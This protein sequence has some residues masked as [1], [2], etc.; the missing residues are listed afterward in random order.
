MLLRSLW[1]LFFPQTPQLLQNFRNK[2]PY[3]TP[4][5]REDSR[6]GQQCPTFSPPQWIPLGPDQREL[7]DALRAQNLRRPSLSR[8]HS[9][10]N[11]AC[12]SEGLLK[13]STLSCMLTTSQAW[14]WQVEKEL[15]KNVICQ[16]GTI[17]GI[18]FGDRPSVF[19]FQYHHLN[20]GILHNLTN[21]SPHLQIGDNNMTALI[22]VP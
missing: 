17:E 12:E 22:A 16:G 7:G 13:W 10:S 14:S 15:S 8:G 2:C 18:G 3:R 5:G 21:S 9:R 20:C 4:F 19:K 11:H 6:R 1:G